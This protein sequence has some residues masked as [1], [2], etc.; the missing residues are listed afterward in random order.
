MQLLKIHTI[1]HFYKS[2]FVML[3]NEAYSATFWSIYKIEKVAKHYNWCR[4]KVANAGEY[5][6]SGIANYLQEEKLFFLLMT[7]LS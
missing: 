3:T 7:V 4:L 1:P 6:F 2:P 5:N